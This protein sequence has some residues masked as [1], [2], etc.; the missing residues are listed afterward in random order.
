MNISNPAGNNLNSKY[1][2][3][4]MFINGLANCPSISIDMDDGA[5]FTRG[6]AVS[7]PFSGHWE[8]WQG[9]QYIRVCIDNFCTNY[10]DQ[11]NNKVF[12][13]SSSLST[14]S[15]TVSMTLYGQDGVSE[16]VGQTKTFNIR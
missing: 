3:V 12:N 9:G 14:G 6:R 16:K 13:T 4:E 15:H 8:T 2:N 1:T 10:T 5:S 7:I 11:D